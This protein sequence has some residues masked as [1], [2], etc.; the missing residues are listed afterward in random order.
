MMG[1]EHLRNI[2][3]L[4]GTDIAAI[5][6][7]DAGMRAASAAL[8]PRALFCDDI[9]ALLA[10]PGLDALL[11]ASPN[12]HHLDQLEAIA[13]AGRA[14]PVLVEAVEAACGLSSSAT[15]VLTSVSTTAAAV[16]GVPRR[17]C[18]R[19]RSFPPRAPSEA[20]TRSSS[21]WF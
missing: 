7:P 10:Q 19:P 20:W 18:S 9:A 17:G 3:L 2:A 1:Q 21:R 8:A 4:P 12:H 15:G 11:V 14:M 16:A 6:E 13:A 5:F